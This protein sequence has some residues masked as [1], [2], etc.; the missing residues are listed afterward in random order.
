VAEMVEIFAAPSA[1]FE[2]RVLPLAPVLKELNW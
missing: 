2:P 1:A